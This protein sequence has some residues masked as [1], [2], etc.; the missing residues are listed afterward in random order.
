MALVSLKAAYTCTDGTTMDLV[1]VV[2]TAAAANAICA[3]AATVA[4]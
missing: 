2:V 4:V 1:V 3:H